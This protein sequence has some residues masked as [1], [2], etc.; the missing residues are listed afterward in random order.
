MWEKRAPPD[1]QSH[2]LYNDTPL[3]LVQLQTHTIPSCMKPAV[4]SSSHHH[5]PGDLRCAQQQC[6][7]V[8]HHYLAPSTPVQ[9]YQL[10]YLLT[11][12]EGAGVVHGDRPTQTPHPDI[13]VHAYG[14]Q[15]RTEHRDHSSC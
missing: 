7:A 6:A 4:R 12:W 15:H 9:G 10:L 11:G 1:L 14:P 13:A 3:P 5:M 2:S 8:K